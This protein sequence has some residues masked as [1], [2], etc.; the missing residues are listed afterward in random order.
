MKDRQL[1]RCPFCKGIK[2]IIDRF[3]HSKSYICKTCE[4]GGRVK[5]SEH[6]K[7]DHGPIFKDRLE[8][9][10]LEI[11]KL[12]LK[13]GDILCFNFSEGYSG[14]SIECF[15]DDIIHSDIIPDGVGGLFLTDGVEVTV[16][17]KK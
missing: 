3:D 13:S 12:Q 14:V 4:G 11:A 9:V 5:A 17:E 16:I 15:R 10:K 7:L 1:I 8:I 2:V 6:D